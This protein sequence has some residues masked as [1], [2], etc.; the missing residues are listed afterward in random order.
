[1]R[2]PVLSAV[3]PTAKEQ[4][5]REAGRARVAV[6]EVPTGTDTAGGSRAATARSVA[7]PAAASADD[8]FANMAASIDPREA[9]ETQILAAADAFARSVGS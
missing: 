1:M 9:M 6:K 3:F 8:F 5:A 2:S 4:V 7:P